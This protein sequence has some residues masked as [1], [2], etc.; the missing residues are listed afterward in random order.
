[1]SFMETVI[2]LDKHFKALH[3]WGGLHDRPKADH[4]A[5]LPRGERP[6]RAPRGKNSWSNLKGSC[7]SL[8]L[9]L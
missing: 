7:Y 5:N 1:M 8:D 9:A 4:H 6:R 2:L 3:A